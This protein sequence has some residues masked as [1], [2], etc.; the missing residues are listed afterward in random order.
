MSKQ[1]LK[2]LGL[3]P[4]DLQPLTISKIQTAKMGAS[5]EIMVELKQKI[6][7]QLGGCQTRF[8][9]RPIVVGGLTHDM[10]LSGPFLRQNKIDQ[11]H[12]RDA[13][14]ING[15]EVPLLTARGR[16]AVPRAEVSSA[17]AYF[18]KKTILAPNSITMCLLRAPEIIR[19]TMSPG[20]VSLD[21]SKQF[22]RTS[23]CHPW[24][25]AIVD[26]KED[27]L[28]RAGVMNTFDKSV[29]MQSGQQYGQVT[30]TCEVNEAH[31]LQARL[32][33]GAIGQ[34]HPGQ[35]GHR[36]PDGVTVSRL[37]QE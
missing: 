29:T 17:P 16:P 15:H 30:L 23:N 1:L 33:A 34:L 37:T 6:Y 26:V 36:P 19:G 32:A 5:L 25:M 20:N 31:S 2:K 13:I 9:C 21:G 35:F 27:G 10:N 22:M 18:V 24:L 14:R 11:I 3:G 8:R 28:I 7:L 4:D 12:S